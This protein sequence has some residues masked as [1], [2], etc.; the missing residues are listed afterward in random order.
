MEKLIKNLV[1][2]VRTRYLCRRRYADVHPRTLTDVIGIAVA[3]VL[4]IVT[5]KK[6]ERGPK[7][8]MQHQK[9]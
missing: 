5:L 1:T 6:R 4:L 7:L 9:K 3:V 8:I 2:P